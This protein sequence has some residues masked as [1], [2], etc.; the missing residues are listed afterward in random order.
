[1]PRRHRPRPHPTLARP[2]H[3]HP[4]LAAAQAHH[5]QP[6]HLGRGPARRNPAAAHPRRPPRRPRRR[7]HPARS[8]R[9]H[10]QRNPR[11]GPPRPARR[12]PRPAL[13]DHDRRPRLRVRDFPRVCGPAPGRL[14][15]RMAGRPQP[16]HRR[17]HHGDAARH[18][19]LRL[20]DRPRPRRRRGGP[21]RLL[22]RNRRPRPDRVH[23]RQPGC[24]RRARRRPPQAVPQ[25]RRPLE[26]PHPGG[27]GLMQLTYHTAD[28]PP[29]TGE[30]PAWKPAPDDIHTL[31]YGYNLADID[32]L[33]RMALSRTVGNPLDHRT[34][35]EVAWSAIA[36]ALYAASEPPTPSD[37]IYAAQREL[38]R[39]TRQEMRHHG[40]HHRDPGQTMRGYA[41]YWNPPA[42]DPLEDVV[43]NRTALWQIWPRLTDCERQVLL[44]LAT[45]GDYAAA[46]DAL[47]ANPGT[48]RVNLRRARRRFLALWHEGETPPGAWGTDRR[49][50]TRARANTSTETEAEAGAPRPPG[51]RKPVTRLVKQRKGRPTHQLVHGRATTYTN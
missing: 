29:D 30:P 3:R 17:H 20:R 51:K 43:V 46:A 49:V 33:A 15:R 23:G 48:F 16:A 31:R 13:P 47:A 1:Q 38:G 5:H 21:R 12:P 24:R 18:A 34:R 35:Y 10:G 42:G 19:Q 44:A 2:H 39:H 7:L 41:A 32:R 9:I 28:L 25:V 8:G 6:R 40:H 22:A 14:V 37:L 36:E 45:T 11:R 27:G 26:D 4:R 50:G